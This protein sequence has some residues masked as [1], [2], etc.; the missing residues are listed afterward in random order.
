M[1]NETSSSAARPSKRRRSLLVAFALAATG[2]AVQPLASGGGAALAASPASSAILADFEGGP[3]AGWFAFFGG[4]TVTTTTQVVGDADPLARPAQVGDNEILTADFNV[5]DFGG[6]GQEYGSS[7]APQDWSGNT[8]F[9]FWF[10][11]TGSGLNYQAEISDNRSNPNADTSERFDY[12]FTDNAAGWQY[13]SIPFEDFTR[14]T[15][16]QP[17][18]APD[19]GFTLTEIWAWAIVLPQGVDTVHFDDVGLGLNV[20]DDF[21]SG[22]PSGVDGNGVPIGFYTFQGAGSSVAL[23]TVATPPAP[24]LPA[25]GGE[26]NTVLQIDVDSTSFAGFIHGFENDVVDTWVA[27]DWTGYEG[28][29]FWMHGNGSGAQL[30]VDLLESRNPGSTS[31]DAERWTVAFVDDFVGWRAFEFPFSDFTRKEIGNGAPNDG[32]TLNEVYGWAFGTLGTGGPQTYFMDDAALYGVGEIAP[33]SVSFESSRTD[34]PEGTT[35]DVVVKLNRPMTDDDP[36]QVSVDYTTESA[37]SIAAEGREFAPTS[38]TLTFVNGGPSSQT[39]PIET[40]DDSKWEWDERIALRIFNPVDVE[41]GFISQASAFIVG[42]DELDPYLLDDFEEGAYLWSADPSIQFAARE[43]AVGDA[44]ARPGQDAYEN[45]LA[46]TTPLIADAAVNGSLCNSGNGNGVI[47]VALLTTDTFDATSVDHTTVRFGDAAEA[48]ASMQTGVAQRHEEDYDGDGDVDLVFH[49]RAD[50]TGYDCDTTHL[51]LTGETFDGD[52]VVANGA[53]AELLRDFAIGEDW[54]GAEALKFW[55]Y[56]TNSGDRITTVLKDNRAPDPGPSG[57]SLVWS[58][59]FDD[60]AGTPP[61]P[62]TWNLEIGDVTPDGKNGWGNDELQ[63]YTDDPANASTDGNGNLAITLREADGSLECFYGTCEYTSARLTSWHKAEFAY[64]RIETRVLVPQGTGIWPAFWSLGNDFDEV[65][66]PQTGEIDIMEFVGRLPNEIFGTIHGPGYAGGA[67]FGNIY[68]FGGPV[69]DDY[70]TFAI[71]WEPDLINWYV[72]DILYHTATPADVAPNE[73]VFNDPL[74]F[75]LNVAVGGNFGGTVGPDLIPPQ[76]ML[77]DYVRVFQGPDT[78]ERWEASFADNFDG[79]QEVVVPFSSFSRSTDQPAG[80]PDDGLTLSEVW[81]YGFGLPEGG[82]TNGSLMVDL[83]RLEPVPPPTEITVTNLDNSGPGSLRQALDDIA[84]GGTI[85]VDPSLAGG[86]ISLAGPLVPPSSVVI[87]GS[88]APG[89]ALDGSGFDRVLI[90]DAGLDV[91]VHD[92]TMTN[93]FGFQLAGCVLNNGSLTL[94]HVTVTGCLM[95]TDAGDFWQG[96]GAIYS[97]GGA[98]LDLV[99]STVSDN[100]AQWSG[101]GVYSFFGTTTNIVRSTISGNVSNDVGGGI[102]SLGD[103]TIVNSTISG[104]ESTGWY[105]GAMFVTDGVVDMNNT[106]VVDNVSPGFAPAAVFVGTFTDASAT[107]NVQNSIIADNVGEGCFLAPFGAGAVA[108]N[109]LGH[110]VFTDVSCFPVGSDLIVADAGVDGLADNGGPT[111]TH[112][113]LAGSPAIDAVNGAVCPATDQRGV[114]R[115]AACDIGSFEFVP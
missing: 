19:D 52:V 62:A 89:L 99:D 11:G 57:W 15:D 65:L 27:Q 73:W 67:S 14:A 81:G 71:E 112:A 90:V 78:A 69:F 1:T 107:L 34:I 85:D 74:F 72:D 97:G 56:G 9:D 98:T 24:E 40:F 47:P 91:T 54:T 36:A 55:Y 25:N 115:D 45:V 30:F 5:F 22:L 48:H 12:V 8:S 76:S 75:L 18:G 28:F 83:A 3:P 113:L 10:H 7:G 29:R 42:D 41:L 26:A 39:F 88:A 44:Q 59:E 37:T 17:G 86:T 93:G 104:N 77:V 43:I 50:E 79:W 20:I 82:T 4:S 58:D 111:A 51:T 13:I 68:D 2:V 96:G 103:A 49:F 92:L 70:H 101:G 110:N 53:P 108:I 31:D 61:D 38:G 105:G 46:A 114:A 6:F 16:F 106:T 80:A 94:D 84:I 102:R 33:L 60:P 100:T 23:A 64:G 95:T 109:S 35:G 66:W 87:D 63:Y 32:L 21:E